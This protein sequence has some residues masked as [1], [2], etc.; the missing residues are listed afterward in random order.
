MSR[1]AGLG[2][3]LGPV[4]LLLLAPGAAG[5]DGQPQVT[6]S[7]VGTDPESPATLHGN[8]NVYVHV[9]YSASAPVKIWV[10]PCFKG[11]SAGAMT[12]GSPVY[13]AGEGEAFGW[14]AFRGAGQVDSIHLQVATGSSGYPFTEQSFPAEFTWDG[15]PG[16]RHEPAAWVAP[17]QEQEK[18][19]EK[20]AYERYASQ[21]VGAVGSIALAV[22]GFMVLAALVAGFLW[23]LW[24]LLRWRG[25]WRA[26]AAIPFLFV[27]LWAAKDIVEISADPTSHNL[28]PFE[29]IEAAVP[30]AIFMSILW[31]LRRRSLAAAR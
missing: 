1:R 22:F 17:F 16:E 29:L 26:L 12:M 10:R 30:V 18:A 6:L 5:A 20:A 4:L 14:F 28:L 21:P 11:R 23:P 13:P 8:D 3:R 19:R 25:R 24:A 27:V 7:I 31:V 9:H 2:W 15:A